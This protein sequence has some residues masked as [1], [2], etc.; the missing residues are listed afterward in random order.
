MNPRSYL[1]MPEILTDYG[2]AMHLYVEDKKIVKTTFSMMKN[3]VG[4]DGQISSYPVDQLYKKLKTKKAKAQLEK[5]VEHLYAR[6]T[7]RVLKGDVFR[8][9]YEL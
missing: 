9:E 2:Y 1:A 6:I 5:D 8:K 4:L 7:G 3:Y